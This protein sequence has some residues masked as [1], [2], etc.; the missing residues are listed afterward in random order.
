MRE[1]SFGHTAFMP[2]I[3]TSEM[4][5]DHI[6]DWSGCRSPAR[7]K[8]RHRRGFKQRMVI[9]AIPMKRA[10]QHGDVIWMHP[11]ALRAIQEVMTPKMDE[12][13]K[14]ASEWTMSHVETQPA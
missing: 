9:R 12:A 1:L 11:E 2:T 8:R 6:E 3:K 5:V 14:Q 7:A 4:M 13:L 10:I